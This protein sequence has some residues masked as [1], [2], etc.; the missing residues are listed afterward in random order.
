[1]FPENIR[2]EF[3]M[4]IEQRSVVNY[5]QYKDMKLPEIVAELA[6]IYREGAFDENKVEYWLQELKLHRSNLGDRSGSDR[7]PL[8]TDA[9]ILQVLESEPWSSVRTI[10]KV[11]NIPALTGHLHLTTSLNMK[12]RHFKCVRHFLDDYFSPKRLEGD[13]EFPD[14]LK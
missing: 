3:Q 13:R 4:E 14:V 10:A 11:L 9:R 8:N 1:M 2:L 6:S 12:S 7:P 5:L